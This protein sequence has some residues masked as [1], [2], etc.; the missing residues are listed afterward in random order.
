MTFVFI[1]LGIA[2]P[3]LIGIYFVTQAFGMRSSARLVE[4]DTMIKVAASV[5]LLYT[6]AL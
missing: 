6:G 2:V 5:A 3:A 4:M 1:A